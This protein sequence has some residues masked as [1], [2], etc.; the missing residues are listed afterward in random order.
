M[1]N[2]ALSQQCEPI[3]SQDSTIKQ[4]DILYSD[5]PSAAT[6]AVSKPPSPRSYW[7]DNTKFFLIFCLLIDHNLLPFHSNGNAT[8]S[9]IFLWNT[10]FL[11]PLFSF[12]SGYFTKR[13]DMTVEQGKQILSRMIIP[14]CIMEVCL[15]TTLIC[16]MYFFPSET[17]W[18][19]T[20]DHM[21][22]WTHLF[23]T[24]TFHGWYLLS[25]CMWRISLPIIS[26]LKHSVMAR[27]YII[28][29]FDHK[30]I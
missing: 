13:T 11:M 12:I 22:S 4:K 21:T 27:T 24:P 6:I 28:I 8:Q 5:T 25:L 7:F 15:K 17:K 1:H 30:Q 16:A 20:F 19:W 9:F 3:N 23:V 18:H 26:N 2:K 29:S 14:Y 10:W